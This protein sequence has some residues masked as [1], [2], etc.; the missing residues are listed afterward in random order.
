MGN[1]QSMVKLVANA[2]MGNLLKIVIFPEL[3]ALIATLLCINYK[4]YGVCGTGPSWAR[5]VY[6]YYGW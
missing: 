6:N 5:K 3:H 4:Y 2:C 1:L